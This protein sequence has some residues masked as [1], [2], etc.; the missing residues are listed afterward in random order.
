MPSGHPLLAGHLP[1]LFSYLPS[2]LS[3]SSLAYFILLIMFSRARYYGD[4]CRKKWVGLHC[5]HAHAGY[6][7][8]R[9]AG[10]LRQ[11]RG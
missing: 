9:A 4:T 7:A 3:S 1:F 11:G 5:M 8:G 6:P 2:Y 10:A